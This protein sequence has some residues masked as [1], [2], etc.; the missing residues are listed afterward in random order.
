MDPGSEKLN[1]NLNS[2]DLQ[3][4]STLIQLDLIHKNF[5]WQNFWSKNLQSSHTLSVCDSTYLLQVHSDCAVDYDSRN[6]LH[7]SVSQW[8]VW[9][10]KGNS[11]RNQDSGQISSQIPSMDA[12][13][14]SNSWCHHGFISWFGW[15]HS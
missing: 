3:S 2:I 10:L 7:G 5:G 12:S 9:L 6:W 1:N 8:L 14:W 13:K 4:K 11:F 15:M